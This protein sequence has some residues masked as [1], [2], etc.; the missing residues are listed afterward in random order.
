MTMKLG[1]WDIRGLAQP[2]RLLL[3]YSGTEYEEKFYSCGEAPNYDKSCWFDVKPKLGLDFPNL[4]YLLDGDIKITQSNAIMRYI[5][6]KHKLVGVTEDEKVR[7]DMLENQAMDFRM[8]IVRLA[9]N[10]DFENLKGEYLKGLPNLLKQFSDFLGKKPWFAGD[11]I[12]FVDFL[13]Y[14]LFDEHR[15]LEPKCLD[16]FKNLKDFVQHFEALEKIAAY[17]KSDRFIKGPFNNKMAK[18]GNKKP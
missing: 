2:I 12:T 8:G 3:E 14:E 15:V 16:E 4:P 18:W 13:M 6:R 7:V 10:P 9:Y 11:K 17:L 5:A 1:Y